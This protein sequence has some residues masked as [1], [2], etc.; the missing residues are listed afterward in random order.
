MKILLAGTYPAGTLEKLRRELPDNEIKTVADQETYNRTEYGEVMVVRSLKT[1]AAALAPKKDLKAVI[2]WGAGYDSVDIEAAGKQGVSVSNTPGVNAYSV[3]ELAVTLMLS[4]GRALVQ[5]NTLTHDGVWDRKQYVE[6]M[7]TL[8]RKTVGIIGGGN[9]GRRVASEVQSFGAEVIYYDAFR[10]SPE[11]EKA[12]GMRFVSLDELVRTSD[13]ISVH[14]PLLDSTR[15]LLGAE[16]IAKMKKN[17]IVVNTSRGGI[18]DDKALYEALKEGR[19]SSAGLDCVEDED[20]SGNPLAKLENVIITPHLGGTS[21]DLADEMIPRIAGMI[22]KF[23]ES[24]TMDH[25]VN[26]KFLAPAKAAV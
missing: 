14:V 25:V 3:A 13:V 15:H 1:T 17:V 11:T 19:I 16:E 18:I 22:R 20:L 8:S 9:I 24:G 26:S 6:R 21:N 10:L 12:Y 7:T 5:Q 4:C 23:E 2:K